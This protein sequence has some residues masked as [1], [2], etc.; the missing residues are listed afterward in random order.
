MNRTDYLI[1]SFKEIGINLTSKQ[2]EQFDKYYDLLVERNKVVN[3][4][5]ITE[6]NEVVIKH[7]VDSVSI[8]RLANLSEPIKIIDIGTGAGFPGI[9]LK[10]VFPNLEIVLLDSL[11]KRLKFLND[12]IEELGLDGNNIRT[13]H[14]RAED[15]GQMES[16]REQF[17]LCVSRAVANLATLSEYCLPFV[18]KSGSFIPYK[19]GD[20]Q[21]EI[22]NARKAI[23]VLGGEIKTVD[24]FSLPNTDIDRTLIKIDKIAMTPKKYPRQAGKPKKEP[25]E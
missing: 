22:T 9:P 21:E 8:I 6:Y 13:I 12:V 18:K 7:F 17:D 19:A 1:S 14:G 10:I 25:I 20:S 2:V 3:L 4:T 5:A 11:N 15:Y 23:K 16:Y 24:S